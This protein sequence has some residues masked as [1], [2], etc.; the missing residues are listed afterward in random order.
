M[1]LPGGRCQPA[2]PPPSHRWDK[3]REGGGGDTSQTLPAGSLKAL[4]TT[5]TICG[6]F[7]FLFLKRQTWQPQLSS[8]AVQFF[9]YCFS[10][11]QPNMCHK[12]TTSTC[13]SQFSRFHRRSSWWDVCLVSRLPSGDAGAGF[14]HAVSLEWSQSDPGLGGADRLD[15]LALF[16]FFCQ[17]WTRRAAVGFYAGWYRKAESDAGKPE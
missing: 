11:S 1:G 2:S 10:F 9:F 13:C 12:R 16:F 7:Y 5:G 15:E 8:Y 3:E 6:Y 4:P 17:S 14:H